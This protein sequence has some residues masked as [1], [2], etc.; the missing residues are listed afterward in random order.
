MRG[1]KIL[2]IVIDQLRADCLTGTGGDGALADHVATP[3]IDALRAEAV[4]FTNHFSVT[5]PC[6]PARASILTGLYAMNHRSVRNGTPLSAG[7]T[8]L[9]LE[10][11]KSGYDP[12]LFGYTDTSHDPRTG[13]PNDPR[14]LSYEGV[15]PG[16]HEIVEMC[17][18]QSYPWRAWLRAKGYALPDY[19][20]FYDPVSPEP[21]VDARPD[22]PPF[23]KAEHSDTAFLTTRFIEEMAVRTDQ[24]WF[25]LLT[26]IRPH[27]P[28]V[29]PAPW[30][31]MYRA[32][33]L[34]LPVRLPSAAQEEAVHPLIAAHRNRPP[35]ESCVKGCEGQLDSRR[36][37]DVQMLRAIYLGL[38]SE[39]DHHVGRVVQFLRD[40]G[41]YDDTLI[42]LTADHG[43]MLGDHH[44]WG[45]QHVY[46]PAWRVPLIIRDP[47][48]PAQHGSTVN[49]LTESTDLMPTILDHVGRNLPHMLDGRS[50]TPF[51]RASPPDDW[52]DCVMLELD[53]GEPD[54][55][56][57]MQTQGRIPLERANLA[58]LREDRWKLVHFNGNLPPLLFDLR[59]DPDEMRNLAND[60][61]QAGQ[62]LRLT[63]KLLSHRMKHADRTLSGMKVMPGGVFGYPG[64]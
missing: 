42:V 58:I 18:D 50:L 34:P 30:N 15:L 14:L 60:P 4:T 39:V 20:H 25:A 54:M 26:Y 63:R 44:M 12:L 21:G 40:S 10:M 61:A 43:E 41:Q 59:D 22:D 1:R 33:D 45:K 29:A 38:V 17:L 3:N 47:D 64:D 11:R 28:L 62:L 23:Y 27:P 19:R 53:F 13:H 36:D 57:A 2:F 7:I 32:E 46:D 8:N 24:D 52:R 37:S 35:M 49:A 48:Q 6:G 9:A 16:F 56:T 5:N 31:H 51:L 55:P